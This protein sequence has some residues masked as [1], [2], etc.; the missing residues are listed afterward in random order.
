[1][2]KILRSNIIQP[3]KTKILS[4]IENRIASKQDTLVSGNNIKTI[5]NTSILGKGNFTLATKTDL[6]TKCDRIILCPAKTTGEIVLTT[7]YTVV[8]YNNNLALGT[9]LL[10]IPLHIRNH[11]KISTGF[12]I[13]VLAD[14]V[15]S[16]GS[17]TPLGVQNLYCPTYE[18]TRLRRR[19]VSIFYTLQ[20]CQLRIMETNF[21]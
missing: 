4:L 7:D 19:V 17:I 21:V 11:P 2:A 18:T 12:T 16:A 8:E 9:Y 14:K 13:D 15:T 5:N 6:N 20:Q 3:L 10:L 1:M